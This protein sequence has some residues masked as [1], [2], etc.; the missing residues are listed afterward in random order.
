LPDTSASLQARFSSN[1][2]GATRLYQTDYL[3]AAQSIAIGGTGTASSR[4]FVGPKEAGVV[5]INFPLA[6]GLG[7]YNKALNLNHFDLL[8]DWGWF[9]FITK[10]MFLAL[11]FFSRLVGNFG[12]AILI[13]TAIVKI[14]FVP[15]ANQSYRSMIKMRHL[16]PQVTALRERTDDRDQAD[17]EILELYKHE[18]VTPPSGCLP[19][20]IQV[21][22]F[23]CLTKV[24]YVTI[25]AHAPFFGWISDLAAPDPSNV[26]NLF[27]LVPFDPTTIP[28]VGQDLQIGAW[29]VMLG[30]TVWRL[31]RKIGPIQFG[32]LRRIMYATL[33]ILVAYSSAHYAASGLVISLAFYNLLSIVHQFLLMKETED[34][35]GDINK[36]S[37]EVLPYGKVQPII[38]L[39]LLAPV[40]QNVPMFLIFWRRS[41]RPK[42]KNGP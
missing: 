18:N 28:L 5:G 20:V 11:D 37:A 41:K 39:M 10:P 36:Y 7:G 6:S 14:I 13:L 27:G 8:I 34:A 33:P 29:P 19:I 4:L 25:D 42:T 35:I 31:Q 15:F 21:L 17:K 1:L 12:V 2:L 24:L 32:W 38:F 26:F 23:F 3:G 30:L 40:L 22:I 9:Y 16:Q